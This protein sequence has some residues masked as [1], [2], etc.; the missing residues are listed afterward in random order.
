MKILHKIKSMLK[1]LTEKLIFA[2]EI[3]KIQKAIQEVE[4][5]YSLPI[6]LDKI[7]YTVNRIQYTSGLYGN[8]L[9]SRSRFDEIFSYIKS[10]KREKNAQKRKIQMT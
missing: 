7:F 2:D 8:D 4:Y 5:H 9:M 6:T 3:K 10:N 1:K